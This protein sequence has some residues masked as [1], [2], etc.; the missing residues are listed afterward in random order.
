MTPIVI[1]SYLLFS[2]Y[3]FPYP[4]DVLIISST[5]TTLVAVAHLMHLRTWFLLLGSGYSRT[6]TGAAG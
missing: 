1:G 5:D 4:F 6:K 3:P 2:G